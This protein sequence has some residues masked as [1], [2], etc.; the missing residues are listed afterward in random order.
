MMSPPMTFFSIAKT[1]R[2][3]D[4]KLINEISKISTIVI[5]SPRLVIGVNCKLL[6]RFGAERVNSQGEVSGGYPSAGK[7]SFEKRILLPISRGTVQ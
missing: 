6:D 3:T 2:Q 4:S 5:L 1:A 7:R